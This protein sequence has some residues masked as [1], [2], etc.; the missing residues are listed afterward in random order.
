MAAVQQF[1]ADEVP[2]DELMFHLV[3]LEGT[4]DEIEAGEAKREGFMLEMASSLEK[5]PDFRKAMIRLITWINLDRTAA[6]W[7]AVNKFY[8]IPASY[9]KM[10]GSMSLATRF[11]SQI[12]P[13]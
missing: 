11:K 1:H 13:F 12:H 4:A 8:D 9:A 10:G 3:P 5:S 7:A 6:R 2:T